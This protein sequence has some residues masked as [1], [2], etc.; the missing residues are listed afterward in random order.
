MLL[1]LISRTGNV[2]KVCLATVFACGVVFLGATG[3]SSG[4]ESH[5]DHTP[6]TAPT[7][8]AAPTSAAAQ[9]TDAP[10]AP[11]PAPQAVPAPE[12]TSIAPPAPEPQAV[13]APQA[14]PAAQTA[15]Q[16]EPAKPAPTLTAPGFEPRAGY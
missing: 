7:S 14:P 10:A 12:A 15:P 2:L 4:T 16:P 11:A 13:P 9:S 8:V 3:C 6:T 5:G 1:L